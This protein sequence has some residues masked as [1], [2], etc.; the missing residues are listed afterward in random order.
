MS[1][2]KELDAN[3]IDLINN[4]NGF[5]LIDCY[6][7]WCN[8]CKQLLQ[9]VDS[10][11][12]NPFPENVQLLKVEISEQQQFKSQFSIKSVPTFLLFEDD[13]LIS[14]INTSNLNTLLSWVTKNAK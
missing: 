8:P 1:Y 11:L 3:V 12:S 5:L 7:E 10:Q 6:A 2:F 4:N 9:M 13:V 14:S